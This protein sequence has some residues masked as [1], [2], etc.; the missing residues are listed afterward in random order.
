MRTPAWRPHGSAARTPA[1]PNAP[2]CMWPPTGRA[3]IPTAPRPLPYWWRPAPGQRSL[4]GAARRNPALHWAASDNDVEALHALLDAGADIEAPGGVFHGGTPL[5]DAV[6]FGQ[7]QAA[8]HLI[9]HGASTTL[10]QAAALGLHSRI[11]DCFPD[12]AHPAQEEINTGFWYACYGGQFNAAVYILNEGA[13]LNW[14]RPQEKLTPLDAAHLCGANSLVQWLGS[15]GARSATG[16][17]RPE[18]PVGAAAGTIPEPERV[19]CPCRDRRSVLA[20]PGPGPYA[21]GESAGGVR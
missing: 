17:P 20:E 16:P 19:T 21:T 12:R 11:R 13:D 14:L 8:Q 5:A 7:W 10:W 15:R 9:E 4:H 18:G 1:V 3:T 2:C 6:G